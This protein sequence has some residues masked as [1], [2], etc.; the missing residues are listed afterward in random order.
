[1]SA[2]DMW[3]SQAGAMLTAILAGVAALQ[4]AIPGRSAAWAL[5]PL[6]SLLVWVGASTAGCIRLAP[7][8]G[9]EPEPAMHVMVCAQFVVLVSVPLCALLVWLLMRA[10]PLR[11]GLTATLG[12]LASAAAAATLLAP[13]HPFDATAADLLVHAVAIVLVV[14]LTR[15]AAARAL[16]RQNNTRGIR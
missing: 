16:G 8:V 3:I 4:T 2:P 9:A 11:P 15:L 13:I 5:L 14:L 10:C 12:G 7:I 6:P 1:M